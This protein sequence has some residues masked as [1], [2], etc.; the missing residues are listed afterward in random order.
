MRLSAV[1]APAVVREQST[2]RQTFVVTNTATGASFT[3]KDV[4]PDRVLYADGRPV[5]VA[6]IGRSTTGSGTIGRTV[7]DLTTGEVVSRS[8]KSYG[9]FVEVTCDAIT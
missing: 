9:D 5:Q 8:G 4:G 3:I 1:L 6:Q 7:T 2:F